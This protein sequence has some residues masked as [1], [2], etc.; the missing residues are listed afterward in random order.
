MQLGQ[1]QGVEDKIQNKDDFIF[2][3]FFKREDLEVG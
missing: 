2:I 3:A 1:Q